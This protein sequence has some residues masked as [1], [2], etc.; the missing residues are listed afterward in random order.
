MSDPLTIEEAQAPPS[1]FARLRG[2]NSWKWWLTI[3]LFLATILTYLD[4]QTMSL[5]ATMIQQENGWDDE[6]YGQLISGFRWAYAFTH[7]PAGLLADHFP[8]RWI[9]ALAVGIWSAAG[10]GAFFVHKGAFTQMFFT[11]GA[12]GVGEA[13]NWPCA[14]RIVAN[15][16]PPTDRGLASGIFNSGAAVGSLVAPFAITP[17]AVAFG[18]RWAFLLMGA[19][20]F[21]WIIVWALATR[22]NTPAYGAIN[23]V[24]TVNYRKLALIVGISAPILFFLIR[25][26]N[27]IVYYIAANSLVVAGVIAAAF[28]VCMA[29][30]WRKYLPLWMLVVV[31]LTVNPCWYFMNEWTTKYMIDQRGLSILQ[32]GMITTP[33]F[34]MADVGNIVSGGFIKFLTV[35]GW[36]LRQARGTTLFVTSMM[37]API[38]FM[39]QIH[40]V[41]LSIGLFCLAALG[42]TAIIANYTACMQD[43]SFK[44]VGLVSGALGLTSNIFAAIVNPQIGKYI[45]VHHDYTLVYYGVALLPVVAFLAIVVFDSFVHRQKKL[46]AVIA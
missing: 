35:R 32:A 2:G 33:I 40:S 12:L 39:T 34:L 36:S 27:D 8:I 16:H 22:K 5:C 46:D 25:Y 21:V 37:I 14:T 44:R 26:C 29:I 23:H 24:R 45:K 9:Y 43:W 13:F 38:A 17:I 31:A 6:K 10:A 7:V 1:L 20:G 11:R 28:V 3:V 15:M 18:W 19:L 41:V 42:I 4:R 30:D